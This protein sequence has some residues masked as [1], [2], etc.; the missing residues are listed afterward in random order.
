VALG[1]GN[2]KGE[3]QV[4]LIENLDKRSGVYEIDPQTAQSLLSNE[5]AKNR[6]PSRNKVAAYVNAMKRDQWRVNGEP[7]LLSKTG[8]LLDGQHRFLA[9]I[10]ADKPFRTVVL[11]GE[12][13]FK[14]L[15]A[16]RPRSA[17]DVLG[18]AGHANTIALAAIARMCI[19]HARAMQ[20]E[21]NPATSG[22]G[23]FAEWK[24]VSNEEVDRWV[25]KHSAITELYAKARQLA[26]RFALIPLSP[27]TAA[28]F[29]SLNV[30]DS[31]VAD[32]WYEGLITGSGLVRGDVRLMLRK[33]YESHRAS[34]KK[35]AIGGMHAFADVC[36]AWSM[37]DREDVKLFRR[38]PVEGFEFIR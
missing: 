14:T 6:P 34:T 28:W 21:A 3:S 1:R 10:E 4:K 37:R 31:N 30:T 17:A 15:G 35:I 24:I 7:I 18:I 13:P 25:S 16:G 8:A 12:Y 36:K 22:G 27:L 33:S 38:L 2:C 20:R 32:S 26:G 11:Y 23:G 9:C 5:A 19:L 29:L